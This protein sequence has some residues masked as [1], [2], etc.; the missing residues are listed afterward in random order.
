MANEFTTEKE[1]MY[2]TPFR[3]RPMLHAEQKDGNQRPMAYTFSDLI[4]KYGAVLR[5]TDLGKAHRRAG[6][7]FKD[8][9]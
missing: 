2:V 3:S 6:T 5:E 4:S 1:I 8:Q 9:L 7:L